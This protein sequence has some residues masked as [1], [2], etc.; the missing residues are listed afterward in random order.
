MMLYADDTTV[1]FASAEIST[2]FQVLTED[3]KLISEWLKHNRL[4]LNLS[5]TNAIFFSNG[6]HST[7]QTVLP[8]LIFDDIL[9]PIVSSTKL[10]GVIID[11]KLKFDLNSKDV[12]RRVAYKVRV[13]LKSAF[14]FDIEF[15]T[16]LFKLFILSTFDYCSS[17]FVHFSSQVDQLRLE[18]SYSNAVYSLLRVNLYD[19]NFSTQNSTMMSLER[20]LKTLINFD[21]LPLKFRYFKRLIRFLFMNITKNPTSSLVKSLMS[22]KKTYGSLRRDPFK[23]PLFKTNLGSFSFLNIAIKILNS[24]LYDDLDLSFYV[25]NNFYKNNQNLLKSF[26]ICLKS[27][28]TWL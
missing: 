6:A 11:N 7:K 27:S 25:F 5:K 10:L 17:L 8:Q 16:I 22:F 13:L 18:R 12:T 20:Q 14:L 19:R 15:K 9:I 3:L 23:T 4:L 24:F 28:N 26:N 1:S 21:I 2:L